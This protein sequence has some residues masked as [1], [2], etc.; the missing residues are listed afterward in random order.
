[1]KKLVTH[2]GSFHA[3]DIF[4]AATLSLYLEKMGESF[5]IIRTRDPEIINSGDYVFDVGGVYDPD[6]NRFDHHQKGGA[7]KRNNGIEYASIGLVWKKFGKDVCGDQK[8]VDLI[9]NR[10]VAPIDAFDNGIDLYKS[11][12]ED[13]APYTVNDVLSIFSKTALENLDKDKQF[14][15]ALIWAK[16]ILGREIKR[17][18]DKIKIAK[19]IQDFYKN[20]SDKRL[21]VINAPKV[22]RY[23]VWDA[24]QEFPDVLFAVYGDN[25]DWTAVAMKTEKG[26]FK[27]RRDFPK[28]WGGLTNDEFRKITGVN[29]AIFCHRSLFLVG[30]K[31]MEGAIALAQKALQ[32]N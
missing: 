6:K 17:N 2:N 18:N 1:M 20:S 3:D 16:E 25:D 10:L 9:D 13:V 26:I 5:E 14:F 27:N 7:G 29:D 12:F 30:A 22:S 21:V 8:V 15:Q 28:A 31:T 32:A 4:A 23:E 19:I 11:N 24:L